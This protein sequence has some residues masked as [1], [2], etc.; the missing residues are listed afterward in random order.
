MTTMDCAMCRCGRPPLCE[1]IENAAR[2]IEELRAHADARRSLIVGISGIDGSGKGY[3]ADRLAQRLNDAGV[4][5]VVVGVD[6]WLRLPSER[7]DPAR[8]GDHFYER[9]IRLDE[10][11]NGC[12]EPLRCTRSF[13]AEFQAC[14]ATS[15]EAYHPMRMCLHNVGVVIAEGI[16]LFKH[17]DQFD[18]RIWID[19]PFT[20]ALARAVARGQEGLPAEQVVRDFETIYFAAQRVHLERDDPRTRADL[21][22]DNG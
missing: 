13:E 20:I 15:A 1:S 14:D 8:P 16:F 18:L 7:F 19:C 21:I 2:K 11:F 6:P 22:I 17:P 5:A 3:V 4:R 10:F 12:I 9:G